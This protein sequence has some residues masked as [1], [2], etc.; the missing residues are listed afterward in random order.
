MKRAGETPAQNEAA[1]A[2]LDHDQGVTRASRARRTA[3]AAVPPHP[4]GLD[5]H[6]EEGL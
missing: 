3:A 2:R 1:L 5:R 4:T 6:D